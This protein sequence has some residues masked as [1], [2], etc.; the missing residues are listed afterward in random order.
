M[1]FHISGV[2]NR[3]FASSFRTTRRVFLTWWIRK[4]RFRDVPL[5]PS[6]YNWVWIA[7]VFRRR[8]LLLYDRPHTF[9]QDSLMTH[10][11]SRVRWPSYWRGWDT[12]S[13]VSALVARDRVM[14][15]WSY[16]PLVAAYIAPTPATTTCWQWRRSSGRSF[17]LPFRQ[18]LDMIRLNWRIYLYQSLCEVSVWWELRGVIL[19]IWMLIFVS[20]ILIIISIIIIKICFII[21]SFMLTITLCLHWRS[22]SSHVHIWTVV[23]IKPL[24]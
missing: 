20:I 18:D 22:L 4:R 5:R 13:L 2:E 11:P 12:V 19:R 24:I 7:G 3:L 23:V 9:I 17:T 8:H 16:R 10:P 14:D 21:M 6:P 1:Y 15:G